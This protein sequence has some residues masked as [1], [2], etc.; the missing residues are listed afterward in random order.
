[1]QGADVATYKTVM[2]G[3]S[4]DGEI[5]RMSCR[6]GRIPSLRS[7]GPLHDPAESRTSVWEPGRTVSVIRQE[8]IRE[9]HSK[10]NIVD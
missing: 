8:R 7:R 1:M 2:Q 10:V 5:A 4:Y 3:S 9:T 6:Q